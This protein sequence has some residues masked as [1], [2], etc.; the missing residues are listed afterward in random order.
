[1]NGCTPRRRRRL[2]PLA[3]TSLVAALLATQLTMAPALAGN[4]CLVKNSTSGESY[5]ASDGSSLQTAI[6]EARHED[7]LVVRGKCVGGFTIKKDLT[8]V[9]KASE[10]FPVATLDGDRSMRVLEVLYATVTLDK[11]RIAHGRGDPGPGGINNAGSLTLIS[12]FVTN[13]KATQWGGGIFN[14]GTLTLRGHSRVNG[15]SAGINGG[16]GIYN[17][18]GE[19][20]V[21][22][23]SHVSRNLTKNVGGGIYGSVRL[24]QSA[25]VSQNGS[26]NSGGGI[27]GSAELNGYSRVSRNVA[28]LNKG[29]TALGGGVAGSAML[30]DRSRISKNKAWSGGGV[31]SSVTMNDESRISGNTARKNGGGICNYEGTT[32]EMNGSSRVSGNV[33]KRDGGGIWDFGEG[34]ITMADTSLIR[35]NTAEG[36][37]PE[38]PT[39]LGGG[40]R[41]CGT[42][43]TGVSDGVNVLNNTPDNISECA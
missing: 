5:P 12:S 25:R 42:T 19:V 18:S 37:T 36:G 22:G 4:T 6:R 26:G 21:R 38:D 32:I 43:L 3:L 8:L 11:L 1:M 34:A 7:V 29:S 23:S 28:G 14:Q 33:A 24:Y 30:N 40:I 15:N 41:T 10:G 20:E 2:F 39:G 31:C 13:N 9:G 35:R 17:L 16:G 27:Y